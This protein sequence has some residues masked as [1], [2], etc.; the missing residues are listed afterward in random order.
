MN[1]RAFYVLIL[2]SMG[3]GWGLTQPLAK[4]AVSG[5]YRHVGVL[6]WQSAISAAVLRSVLALQGKRLPMTSD[7][8]RFYVLIALIGTVL[9]QTASFQ[10]LVYLPAGIVSILLSL[11]PIFAFPIALGFRL[12][13]FRMIRLAGL[14]CGAFGVLLLVAPE[15]SLPDPAM[16]WFIPLA[17]IAPAF[18]GLEG[19]FVA[20]FGTGGTDPIQLLCGASIMG[21]F[22]TLPLALATGN[23]ISPLPPYGAPDYALVASSVIHAFVYTSYV[24]LV[25]RAGSVFAAQVSYTVTGFGVFW[26]MLIL[27]ES[28]SAYI[29]AALAL[30]MLGI[31]LVR[32]RS[33]NVSATPG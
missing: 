11:V 29:W 4:I 33:K 23:W 20:R 8:L 13:R 15:A 5:E 19:N 22:I 18:Y 2:V 28:Y 21:I 3:A 27:G 25:Q 1:Q 32:P 6:F 26:A 16:V 7:A 10:A 14:L 9:P 24:W 12:E 30:I 31:L 17:L